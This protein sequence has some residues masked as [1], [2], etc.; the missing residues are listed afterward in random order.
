MIWA[1]EPTPAQ[2]RALEEYSRSLHQQQNKRQ[3]W[4]VEDQQFAQQRAAHLEVLKEYVSSLQSLY[5]R[6]ERREYL[7]RS[8]QQRSI[9][10]NARQQHYLGQGIYFDLVTHIRWT[11]CSVGQSWD[12]LTCSGEPIQMTWRQALNLAT[13]FD[14]AGL[15]NWR[16]PSAEELQSLVYCD[17]ADGGYRDNLY[18]G[19]CVASYQSPTINPNYFPNANNGR[20]WS[21]TP[22]TSNDTLQRVVDFD[23]GNSYDVDHAY[24]Y[25]LRLVHD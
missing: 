4:S 21:D 20:Y 9:E 18:Y 23:D 12:G 5:L 15:D 22:G 8:K 3:S 10:L 24:A 2:L 13:E 14:F 17:G 7:L 6:K 1:Y 11:R 19:G 16:L 25:Y